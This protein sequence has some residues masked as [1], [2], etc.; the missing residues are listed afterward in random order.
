[1]E[2]YYIYHARGIFTASA[3]Y[4]EKSQSEILD[5]ILASYPAFVQLASFDSKQEAEK[6]YGKYDNDISVRKNKD[7]VIVNYSIYTL[8]AEN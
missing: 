4:A 5:D 7:G 2:K 8:K 1:V 3:A 6:E